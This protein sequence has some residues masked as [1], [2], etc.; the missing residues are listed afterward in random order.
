[1]LSAPRPRT[2]D[3]AV[4]PVGSQVREVVELC[5]DVAASRPQPNRELD[6]YLLD[7]TS[8]QEQAH[9]LIRRHNSSTLL[10]VGDD[11][12]CSVPVAAFTLTDVVVV[13]CDPRIVE[14]LRAWSDRL[15]LANLH[16]VEGTVDDLRSALGS[17]HGSFTDYY[18]NPPFDRRGRGRAICSWLTELVP[19]CAPKA[20]G[21]VVLPVAGS[22]QV[23][24]D[25]VWLNV[26][27]HC[28]LS[29]LAITEVGSLRHFYE[30]TTDPDIESC[31]VHLRRLGL[32]VLDR[33]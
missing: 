23:W 30:G 33:A 9:E 26:Q 1:M 8:L 10:M 29:G 4:S 24:I 6:Q 15:N 31:N 25:Q 3:S 19:A 16:A 2:G 11:D 32:D 12:H 28:S 14:S 18:I 17:R 7:G 5:R 27:R 22:E 13:E 21:V 20:S